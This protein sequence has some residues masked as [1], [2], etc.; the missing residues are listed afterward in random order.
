MKEI[1]QYIRNFDEQIEIAHQ[2]MQNTFLKIS[3]ADENIR[4]AIFKRILKN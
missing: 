1:K 3:T 2:Q 4:S